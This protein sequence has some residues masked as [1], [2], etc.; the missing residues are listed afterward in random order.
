[1]MHYAGLL[2]ESYHDQLLTGWC[3]KEKPVH[4]WK[5]MILN[6]NNH[7]RSIN[8]GYRSDMMKRKIKFYE[9]FASFVDDHTIELVNNKGKTQT[10]TSKYFVIAVGGRPSYPDIPGAK[11][12]GITSDD[13]FWME[14]EPGK[15]LVVGASYVALECAGFLH[16][17]G[18][19]VTVMVRS[20]LL[21]GFD[22][23]MANKIGEDMENLGVKFIR[24]AV[25]TRIEKN[26]ET[27][28]LTCYYQV[29]DEELSIEVDTVLF[30]VGRY[31][32]TKELH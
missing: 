28:K 11:E 27:E 8:F 17:F 5:E 10:V 20:I 16:A 12:Y 6:I 7:I 31:A 23:D 32:V 4:D 14:R 29:G 25:P 30:A 3:H 15:T 2:G 18:Y 13:I 21:R 26:E 24:E 9:E 1:M 19:D 22:Q